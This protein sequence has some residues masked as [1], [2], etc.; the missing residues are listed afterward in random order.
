MIL[1]I[2][3]AWLVLAGLAALFLYCC[4]RVS[5]G[6][7]RELADEDFT[8]GLSRRPTGAWTRNTWCHVRRPQR[9][10]EGLLVSLGDALTGVERERRCERSTRMRRR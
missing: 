2:L 5:N 9:S 7:D 8:A 10:A 6:L 4:S 1:T 3:A